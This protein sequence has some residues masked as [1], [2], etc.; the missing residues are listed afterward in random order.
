MVMIGL[1]LYEMHRANEVAYDVQ[2]YVHIN[3]GWS[4]M[5][6]MQI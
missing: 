5:L 2:I 1:Y 4:Y 3:L 6:G